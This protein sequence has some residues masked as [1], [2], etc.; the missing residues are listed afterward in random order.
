MIATMVEISSGTSDKNIL[1]ST[2][3]K[4]YAKMHYLI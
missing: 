2:I 3:L 1:V 4:I